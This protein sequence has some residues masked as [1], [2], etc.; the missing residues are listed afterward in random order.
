[1]VDAAFAGRARELDVCLSKAIAAGTTSGSILF[2]VLRQLGGLHRA[3]LAI[4]A[5]SNGAREARE[6]RVHFRRKDAVE[7]ALRM[8][9]AARLERAMQAIAQAQLET[10]LRPALGD[11]ILRRAL[12]ELAIA[13]RRKE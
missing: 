9:S 3:C 4:E 13:A 11:A 2:S 6:M 8:W 5:G 12:T 10:R 7:A 1:V